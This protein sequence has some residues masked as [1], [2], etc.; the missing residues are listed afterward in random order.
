MKRIIV[1]LLISLLL[2]ATFTS[3]FQF[4][5]DERIRIY[6][7]ENVLKGFTSSSADANDE[8]QELLD[9]MFESQLNVFCAGKFLYK[10]GKNGELQ[11]AMLNL[12]A[13]KNPL[14]KS[15]SR[16]DEDKQFE[17]TPEQSDKNQEK[18]QKLFKG[19]Y[20]VVTTLNG[21]IL[22]T[23]GPKAE[24]PFVKSTK[25]GIISLLQSKVCKYKLLFLFFF[26]LKIFVFVKY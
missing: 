13:V 10:D 11:E 2:L 21:K 3:G 24:H 7:Y 1:V 26:F 20:G 18:L 22:K 12:V 9:N 17:E 14:L 5:C 23:F 16:K 6:K 15:E 4:D 25:T 19:V 8:N